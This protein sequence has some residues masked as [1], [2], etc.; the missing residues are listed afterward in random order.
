MVEGVSA[1]GVFDVILTYGAA[2]FLRSRQLC[3]HSRTSQHFM[4]PDGSSPCSQELS[5]GP[6]PEPDRPS[7]HHPILS[8][9]SILILSTHLRLGLP[10]GLLPSAFPTNILYAFDVILK[11]NLWVY[12]KVNEIV[13][14]IKY[15][16]RTI[17]ATI[18]SVWG[19][20]FHHHL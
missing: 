14:W 1:A 19:I 15:I 9:R 10:S 6:F 11:Q 16:T 18:C 20:D 17:E 5:T 2:P 13:L 12:G 4:E 3:S 8:L 7:P